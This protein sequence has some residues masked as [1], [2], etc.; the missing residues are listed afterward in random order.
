MWNEKTWKLSHEEKLKIRNVDISI[1]VGMIDHRRIKLWSDN[2][3][4]GEFIDNQKGIFDEEQLQ[5]MLIDEEDVSTLAKEIEED[6]KINEP[7]MVYEKGAAVVEGNRRLVANRILF[8]K[9]SQLWRDIPIKVIPKDVSL[10][11]IDQY[12]GD[13][14]LKGKR[15]WSAYN[16]ARFLGKK[17]KWEE[18][19]D[20][21]FKS[22]SQ[23]FKYTLPDVKKVAFT[24]KDMEE[25]DVADKSMYSQMEILNTNKDIK[26]MFEAIPDSKKKIIKSIKQNKLGTDLEFRKYMPAIIQTGD[27]KLIKK[28]INQ[29]I[30]WDKAVEKAKSQG[31]TKREN[32][33]IERFY[34]FISEEAKIKNIILGFE[35]SNFNRTKTQLK[36][37]AKNA[38][39][40]Y[41]AMLSKK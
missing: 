4:M 13:L 30:T 34:E 22:V 41:E 6:G 11:V 15:G 26:G 36:K 9:D 33:T 20:K 3:R 18:P 37:I 27:K 39:F 35:G 5:K 40:L 1:K 28:V 32:V 21:Q 29:E 38:K 10:D 31:T 16:K 23:E 19:L 25:H 2:P 14:H 24:Y 8:K 17:I 12:L 7:L